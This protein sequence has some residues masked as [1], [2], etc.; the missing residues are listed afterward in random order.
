GRGL[1]L[2]AELRD[3]PVGNFPQLGEL[4]R[5]GVLL[6]RLS[7]S[8]TLVWGPTVGLVWPVSSVGSR[9]LLHALTEPVD[10]GCDMACA[11]VTASTDEPSPG[12]RHCDEAAL[13]HLQRVKGGEQA[14]GAVENSSDR[15][16]VGGG[17]S[18]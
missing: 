3:F 1:V 17:T 18:D 10:D 13:D 12:T 6:C 5:I 4:A 15:A 11:H 16:C 8:P 2:S 14:F 7:G 9:S